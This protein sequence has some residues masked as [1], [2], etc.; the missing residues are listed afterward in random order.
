[1]RLRRWFW[2]QLS[3]LGLGV[4]FVVL[5]ADQLHKWWMIH[6]FDIAARG[7]VEVTPFFDLVLVWNKGISYGLLSQDSDLGRLF[8]VGFA[9]VIT[10]GLAVWLARIRSRLLAVS[11]GLIIGGAIGNAIDRLIYGA[12]ADFFSFHAYGFYWYVF[13]IADVAIVAGVAGLFYDSL[14]PSH[15]IVSKPAEESSVKIREQKV[16]KDDGAP[17]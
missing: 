6:V 15:K 2:G 12:V 7:R 9:V 4:A 10:L 11:V 16:R 14:L 3:P 1:M 17:E 5:T 8:L 13:N